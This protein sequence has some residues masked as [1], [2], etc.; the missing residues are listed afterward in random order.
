MLLLRCFF[1][2][3]CSLLACSSSSVAQ[4]T[5]PDTVPHNH[6]AVFSAWDYRFEGPDTLPAGQTTIRLHNRGKEPHQ[7]QVLKLDGGKSPADLTAALQSGNRTVPKW[8]KQMGG[9]NSVGAGS[10]S[11]AT[12]YLEPGSYVLMC[13][14][15]DQHHKTHAALG[16]QKALRVA[17]NP[18]PPAEYQGN[19]HMA[20]FEY[21][22]VVVQ[23]L[24]K[25]RHTFYVINRGNQRH[26]ASI[27]RLNPGASAQDVLT[28]LKQD[29]SP[30]LPGTFV[31]GMSGL[32][33]GRE[34]TF[35]AELRQGRYAIMC[36]FSNPR[37]SESH[38]ARGM[39]MTFTVE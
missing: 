1:V 31:G 19:L 7:L 8:A 22:F 32:E 13:G 14:I 27:I 38:A 35:T 16:M 18:R 24:N 26:Q 17:N 11:E 28:A 6:V 12:I 10:E 33:P 29:P 30:P 3:T 2:L 37:T 34:G 21:E 5:P 23:P 9:P 36:L 20:M 39:V 25:G 15:P 4:G